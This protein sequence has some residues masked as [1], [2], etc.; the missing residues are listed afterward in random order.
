MKRL[1]CIALLVAFSLLLAASVA[2]AKDIGKSVIE[3]ENVYLP[4]NADDTA[5]FM[6][7]NLGNINQKQV[8]DVTTLDQKAS[9][10]TI[11]R[12]VNNVTKTIAVPIAQDVRS[13]DPRVSSSI[14]PPPGSKVTARDGFIDFGNMVPNKDKTKPNNKLAEATTFQ[15][16]DTVKVKLVFNGNVPFVTS[17]GVY[18]QGDATGTNLSQVG[19]FKLKGAKAKFDPQYTATND[20]D[21]SVF[22]GNATFTVKNLSF[23]SNQT[24]AQFDALDLD[25]ILAG[26]LPPDA[27]TPEPDFSLDSSNTSSGSFPPLQLFDNPFLEPDPGKF[28]VAVGQLFDPDTGTLSSFIEGF[29]AVPA[30]PTVLLFGPGLALLAGWNKRRR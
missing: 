21:L 18:S 30:P 27:T 4:K 16:K 7:I 6:R 2:S 3:F 28:D 10:A 12:V 22:P 15:P 25:A 13:T 29:Q 1:S 5:D 11:E 14:V 24:E 9:T 23:L 17:G 19:S 26:I 20:L 8:F